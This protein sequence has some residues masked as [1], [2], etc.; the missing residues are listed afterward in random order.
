MIRIYSAVLSVLMLFSVIG[1][2]NAKITLINDYK[3]E[4]KRDVQ[5][6]S[7]KSLGAGYYDH[8]PAGVNCDTITIHG[9]KCYNNCETTCTEYDYPYT[10]Q[11]SCTNDGG[12]VGASCTFSGVT[13]YKC[14]CPSGY[15]TCD[16]PKVGTLPAC[17]VGGVT[18]YGECHC[19]EGWKVCSSPKVG[20]G[21]SCEEMNGISRVKL[22]E[23]CSCP[24][25]YN[26]CVSPEVGNGTA[27]IEGGDTKY[28]SCKCPDSWVTCDSPKIGVGTAC[29][30]NG[31]T[32][33]ESCTCPSGWTTCSS[34][35]MGAGQG[36][37][38]NSGTLYASCS[39]D[40]S[41]YP[42]T[43]C[44]AGQ[45]LSGGSCTD[46]GGIV[47]RSAC[48]Y[49]G[50]CGEGYVTC[51]CY[52]CVARGASCT[53]A[54]GTKYRFCRSGCQ[55]SNGPAGDYAIT[56]AG[57][58]SG[59]VLYLYTGGTNPIYGCLDDISVEAAN[60]IATPVAVVVDPTHKIAISLDEGYTTW[61]TVDD[62][63][64]ASSFA[65]DY[66]GQ[67]IN[68]PV[69]MDYEND[70]CVIKERNSNQYDYPTN[71]LN[72]TYNTS[73]LDLGK[74]RAF[75]VALVDKAD[76]FL[77]DVAQT[78]ANIE[79]IPSAQA[80][81]PVSGGN[82]IERG[83]ECNA[84]FP[85]DCCRTD[86]PGYCAGTWSCHGGPNWVCN[87]YASC[88]PSGGSTGGGHGNGSGCTNGRTLCFP[89][90]GHD[91]ETCCPYGV[92]SCNTYCT[93]CYVTPTSGSTQPDAPSPACAGYSVPSCPST[94]IDGG[95]G[96][97]CPAGGY[98]FCTK[99]HA[100]EGYLDC[101]IM[102][103]VVSSGVCAP[104][105]AGMTSDNKIRF[106][107]YSSSSTSGDYKTYED[108]NF[109]DNN[110]Y[111]NPARVYIG[112][113]MYTGLNVPVECQKSNNSQYYACRIKTTG[114]SDFGWG[115]NTSYLYRGINADYALTRCTSSDYANK[116]NY[117]S[118]QNDSQVLSNY[119]NPTCGCAHNKRYWE[120]GEH[121]I[122]DTCY[123]SVS[124][125]LKND[126]ST[127]VYSAGYSG[128]FYPVKSPYSDWIGA[129]MSYYVTDN[130]SS[131]YYNHAHIGGCVVP[132]NN[133]EPP[134]YFKACHERCNLYGA[135]EDSAAY[136]QMIVG[137]S[138]G[139]YE[140]V[141]YP[142]VLLSG[143]NPILLSSES[144]ITTI[145]DDDHP[146]VNRGPT[147]MYKTFLK[148]YC[149]VAKVCDPR[150]GSI[151]G[152]NSYTCQ[153]DNNHC[154][155]SVFDPV[156]T[157]SAYG[158]Y[159][160]PGGRIYT[161]V[162]LRNTPVY[163]PLWGPWI[164]WEQDLAN[165]GLVSSYY[166]SLVHG[167]GTAWFDEDWSDDNNMPGTEGY[168]LYSYPVF[169]EHPSFWSNAVPNCSENSGDEM[170]LNVCKLYVNKLG[171]IVKLNS[172]ISTSN[173]D[174]ANIPA[175]R[176]DDQIYGANGWYNYNLTNC[177]TYNAT[178][179][180][181]YKNGN[182]YCLKGFY[183]K[184]VG[185]NS[186]QSSATAGKSY[187]NAILAISGQ[188]AAF[189]GQFADAEAVESCAPLTAGAVSEPIH[190]FI[191]T[192][193]AAWARAKGTNWFLPTYHDMSAAF[194]NVIRRGL[195][196][197][198][199]AG[200]ASVLPLVT[201]QCFWT[202]IQGSTIEGDWAIFD[203]AGMACNWS[204]GVEYELGARTEPAS[205]RAF[206]DYSGSYG[207][208]PHTV[209]THQIQEQYGLDLGDGN[210]IIP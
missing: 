179:I 206:L 37:S 134:T 72:G 185:T 114:N 138:I 209:P 31:V 54:E 139:T 68:S 130:T 150:S 67:I 208:I 5:E 117:V 168:D 136:N 149:D 200:N 12:I 207:S 143:A 87:P 194:A 156:V 51:N 124:P 182:N 1:E 186:N 9:R 86:P 165:G 163:R 16:A 78:I 140:G 93:I 173:G 158:Y 191:E 33:Y 132:K 126:A 56:C 135:P 133:G 184:N 49:A 188:T 127:T 145:G 155:P 46:S 148:E 162:K 90:A 71:I 13:R 183:I 174:H 100:C 105:V 190:Y 167:Y 111:I 118:S 96:V 178:I 120:S 197:G 187:T 154:F 198:N 122:Y 181:C 63:D 89:G 28:S 204:N 108:Y 147:Y 38:S 98:G 153:I 110:L 58:V 39:C 169:T 164:D 42:Y 6:W 32:K 94:G 180:N 76:R 70:Q 88:G 81:P 21:P 75:E 189:S 62:M 69:Y 171:G 113:S 23:T 45:N 7:C 125:N 202:S 142:Q 24:N 84:T 57:C 101:G 66:R 52:N 43:S 116:C 15:T 129:D 121:R 18:K 137:A 40:P 20:N 166:D 112:G 91:C 119:L 35:T 64:H 193:A 55:I 60:A 203:M 50:D 83:I 10:I 30:K 141:A 99:P 92:G 82:C 47:H 170:W 73:Y 61:M 26:V 59:S 103:G 199:P 27:C 210:G 77:H 29:T 74:L 109:T 177:R 4:Y 79:L 159:F 11:S 123:Y 205:V 53:D 152:D 85:G 107:V 22:Y 201:E 95:E 41:V 106:P 19:P 104:A 176:N 161:D 25:N 102:G 144:S 3:M 146:I 195:K 65:K 80:A 157:I 8:L 131:N 97:L 160:E 14:S 34:P 172:S 192:P 44:P 48:V 2:A 115:S 196:I 151:P 36:C 128:L 17:T 175:L